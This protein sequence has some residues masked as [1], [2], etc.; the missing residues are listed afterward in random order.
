MKRFADSNHTLHGLRNS[1]NREQS[2]RRVN[3]KTKKVGRQ[4][5]RKIMEKCR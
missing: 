2:E 3:N 5:W 1:L 4:E